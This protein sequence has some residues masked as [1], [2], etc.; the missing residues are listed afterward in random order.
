MNDFDQITTIGSSGTG[1]TQLSSPGDLSIDT[2]R[3]HLCICDTGNNRLSLWD[4]NGKSHIKVKSRYGN[5]SEYAFDN[6]NGIMYT[7]NTFIVSNSNEL[8]MLKHDL[9]YIKRVTGFSTPKGL[10]TDG[11]YIYLCDSGNNRIVKMSKELVTDSTYSVTSPAYISHCRSSS[12]L[13]VTTGESNKIYNLSTSLALRSSFGASGTGNGQ[14]TTA[15]G[16]TIIGDKVYVIDVN[17][18]TWAIQRV[19]VFSEGT[20]TYHSNDTFTRPNGIDSYDNMLF[21]SQLSSDNIVVAYNYEPSR[22]WTSD[23]GLKFQDTPGLNPYVFDGGDLIVGATDETS[24]NH[25]QEEDVQSERFAWSE[26]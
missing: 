24:P 11:I 2:N 20:G 18:S 13:F 10:C 23:T 4:L 21:I 14:F 3:I 6:L 26:E 19:Q 25:W 22:S 15:T 9:T 5:Y 17:T 16:I 8:V 12:S 1:D 7:D